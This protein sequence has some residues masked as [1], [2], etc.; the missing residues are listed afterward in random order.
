MPAL[1]FLHMQCRF[2]RLP[3]A[4][5]NWCPRASGSFQDAKT[6]QESG[7]MPFSLSFPGSDALC[8]PRTLPRS[9]ILSIVG[10]MHDGEVQLRLWLCEK[11]RFCNDIGRRHNASVFGNSSHCTNCLQSQPALNYHA[12]SVTSGRQGPRAPAMISSQK[13]I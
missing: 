11:Y 6:W 2:M 7:M 10:S 9:S 13:L 3:A 12:S 5:G 4:P 1:V 8:I